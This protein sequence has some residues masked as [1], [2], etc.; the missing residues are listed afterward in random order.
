M[1]N[2]V[3]LPVS[4][5]SRAGIDVEPVSEGADAASPILVEQLLEEMPIGFM[6]VD[7]QL[8]ITAVNRSAERQWGYRREDI[9]GKGLWELFPDAATPDVLAR[10][11]R[12]AETGEPVQFEA[13]YEPLR[14]WIQIHAFLTPG[15]PGFSVFYLD[16]TER[17]LAEA[18]RE[19]AEARYR[20]IVEE[21]P[22]IT[23]L[24][25]VEEGRSSNVY[26]SPQAKTL[27]G[28]SPEEWRLN[29]DLWRRILHPDDRAA[30]VAEDARC[31]KLAI[32]FEAEYRMYARDGRIVWFHDRFTP[33]PDETGEPA[34]MHGVMVDITAYRGA[35]AAIER[36]DEILAAVGFAADRLLQSPSW[37]AVID[38]VLARLG[39][40]SGVGHV[41]L[42]ELRP[43]PGALLGTSRAEWLAAGASS[44]ARDLDDVPHPEM[45]DWIPRLERGECFADRVVEH[46]A[47]FAAV[48]IES[49]VVAPVIVGASTW[50]FLILTDVTRAGT[51]SAAEVDAIA[52]AAAAV[53]AAMGRQCTELA[54]RESE[55]RF[56]QMAEEAPDVVFR[57]RLVPDLALEYVS[58]AIERVSGYTP[59]EVLADLG[60]VCSM[61]HPEDQP[62]LQD[63]LRGSDH[64]PTLR[65]IARDGRMVWTEQRAVNV[66]NDAGRI[67]AIEGIARDVSDR[68]T[69][70]QN[71]RQSFEALTESNE[72]RRQLLSRLVRAQEEERQRIANDIHDDSIQ[73]MTAVGM[74][75]GMLR[76]Y[77]TDPG[78]ARALRTA[79][80]TVALSIQ[81]L[82]RLVFDLHPL[83]LD[84]SGFVAALKDHVHR[85]EEDDG[86]TVTIDDG[87]TSEPS[88]EA[89]T[90]LYRIAQEALTN[91][92]KH[93]HA[94]T[95]QI[96]LR[97]EGGGVGVS[98]VD[99]GSGFDPTTETAPLPG[100][101]GLPSM[102]ERA[103][104]AGGW[105]RIES[106]P[107]EGTRVEYWIP[108]FT[109]P[110]DAPVAG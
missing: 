80:E 41:N 43:T 50:G 99:D 77:D 109:T 110:D 21:V 95:V 72:E 14:L 32:P 101:V 91:I 18:E 94:Q 9:V 38:E 87:M 8:R 66:V 25:R 102:R 63:F 42:V 67:V 88:R 55:E 106:A 24:D 36:K 39:R 31:R 48:G 23:Y 90:I 4:T 92:R 29:A 51:W 46:P 75:L 78:S 12:L 73:I 103:T 108:A 17:R 22:A 58:P 34:L 98:I 27:L 97:Q 62:R 93:A 35:Q 20:Q 60:L 16:V 54:L 40:A 89:R 3:T 71:L 49:Y 65:W 84:N 7:D 104:L 57:I 6:S 74:R 79:E 28:Y 19:A 44:I 69:A 15:R 10:M 64:A 81:R 1:T 61:I 45:L 105:C 107:G 13:F 5:F 26:V 76:G 85:L 53:S 100:H 59:E 70:E 47:C 30:V 86:L 33:V 11:Q 96:S 37:E 52:G 2:G 82:R 83:S 68:M 56:R